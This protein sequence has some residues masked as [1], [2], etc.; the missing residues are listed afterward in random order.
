MHRKREHPAPEVGGRSVGGAGAE[1]RQEQLGRLERRGRRSL[2]PA[3]G[4]RVG[5]AG[6]GEGEDGLCQVGPGDLRRVTLGPS[7]Q[8]AGGVEAQADA[9]AGPARAVGVSTLFRS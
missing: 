9:G 3:E 6:G 1:L 8:V 2:E 5:R 7:L 4:P